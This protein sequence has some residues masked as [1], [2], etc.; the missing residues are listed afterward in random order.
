MN[1][2]TAAFRA[3]LALDVPIIQAPM[4]GVQGSALAIAVSSAGGLGSLPCAM[5][6]AGGISAERFAV[7]IAI[8]RKRPESMS[9]CAAVT[10]AKIMSTSPEATPTTPCDTPLYGT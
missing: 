8:G 1:A 5:L 3:R 7:L 6:D 4:A 10:L 9:G 2:Q